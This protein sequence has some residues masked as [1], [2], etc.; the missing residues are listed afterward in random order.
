M[1]FVRAVSLVITSTFP[2][3][4]RLYGLSGN[5]QKAQEKILFPERLQSSYIR[6]VVN[7]IIPMLISW[8]WL[9]LYYGY[10]DVY[11]GKMGKEFQGL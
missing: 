1:L 8:R 6:S 5:N 3:Y 2:F 4:K 9:I 11:W 10:T 7:N